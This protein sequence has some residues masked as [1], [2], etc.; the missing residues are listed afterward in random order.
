M[1]VEPSLAK[2]PDFDKLKSMANAIRILAADAVE[3]ATSGHPGMPMGMADVATILFNNFL[4]FN[5][6]DPSW[7]NRDRF[8]LSAGHGSMLLY[9]LLHL[10]GYKDFSI[11][12]LKQFRQLHAK[13]A[14][15]PEYGH[16][17]GIETTTGPLGQGLANAV[18]MA[19]AEKLRASRFGDKI[20]D[21]YTYVIVGDGCL[22][23]GISQEAI[24]FA[25]H[26][27]LNKL[28]VLF[29]DNEISI[30]GPTNLSTSEDQCARFKACNWNVQKIDGHNMAEIYAAIEKAQKSD[31]PTMIACK[32]NI[33]QGSPNKVGSSSSHGSPLGADEIKLVRKALNWESEPF[34]IPK[35]IKQDWLNAGKRSL[36]EFDNWQKDFAKLD[37]KQQEQLLGKTEFDLN[38]LVSELKKEYAKLKPN[39]ATR[40]SSNEILKT[41][42]EQLP[43]LIGG[44]ADLTGSNLTK[45][46][47]TK[48][49]NKNDF[50]GSYIYYGIREH[51]MAAIMNGLALYGGFIPYGGTFLVFSDYCRPA[52]RLS[53]LMN[54]Q[55]IYVLTHD[56]IGLGED[57][58]THQPVEHLASL[59]VIPNLN[60]FRPADVIETLEAW[61]LALENKH[62]PSIIVLTRQEVPALR[63]E[64][65]ENLSAKGAYILAEF[66][67]EHKV[68][69]FATGSEVSLAMIAK[70]KLEEQNIG[71][72]I[73][74]VPSMELFK[75]QPMEYQVSL[76]CNNSIKVAVEAALKQGWEG[77][78]GPHGI[79][80]GMQGFGA[81]A[82]ASDLYNY[83][84]ITAENIVEKVVN[85]IKDR[86]K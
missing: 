76:L 7:P 6:N 46:N 12:E 36:V 74:S 64:E 28:I 16:A 23:E 45:T 33:A 80:V 15:H 58:P 48:P 8:V 27:N 55:V 22:M 30:D 3:K 69:I 86:E 61:Q 25:A 41:L 65:K 67:G 85:K 9:S 21:N 72:R 26:L 11:E 4:K 2:K 63:N 49:I 5:P 47:S 51:A 75:K 31:K 29:D 42:T 19:L 18:G 1:A 20:V 56:S 71:T 54:I 34:V 40:K 24:S 37:K 83:F 62:T 52:I 84:G 39:W 70:E 78:I 17:E 57:G 68:T 38:N 13:T 66:K 82:K 43:Q 44:S 59:R 77:F 14:G 73:V 53:A 60:V 50:S 79:F 10:T 35:E 32:T 81:S